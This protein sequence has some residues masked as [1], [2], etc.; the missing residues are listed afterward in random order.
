[1][2]IHG[3]AIPAFQKLDLLKDILSFANETLDRKDSFMDMAAAIIKAPE[4]AC[5]EHLLSPWESRYW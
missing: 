3:L 5:P 4:V 2:A 1:G